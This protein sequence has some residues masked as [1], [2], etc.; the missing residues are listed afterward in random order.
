MRFFEIS[1]P[2]YALIKAK[3]EKDAT[4][5]YTEQVCDVSSGEEFEEFK[6]GMKEITKEQA[7]T[8]IKG[9]IDDDT[10]QPVSNEEIERAISQEITEILLIDSYLV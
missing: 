7:K 9:A 5:I 8:A 10:G 4:K 3:D 2:Y 1:D 6:Q